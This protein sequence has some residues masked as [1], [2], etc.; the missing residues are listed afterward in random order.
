MVKPEIKYVTQDMRSE[1][2]KDR[3]QRDR[4][5]ALFEVPI[6][7]L[8]ERYDKSVAWDKDGTVLNNDYYDI[9][10]VLQYT[11]HIATPEQVNDSIESIIK[12]IENIEAQFRNHRH[13]MTKV[14]SET[15]EY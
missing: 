2:I 15:P 4:V 3:Q 12:R 1:D 14:Y 6:R 8:L 9:P 7:E 11:F 10:L 13:D 5:E